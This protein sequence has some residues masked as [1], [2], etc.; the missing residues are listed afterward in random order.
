MPIMNESDSSDDERPRKRKREHRH[1]TTQVAATRTVTGSK[2]RGRY[3]IASLHD[4]ASLPQP[5]FLLHARQQRYGN[6]YG[7]INIADNA[8]A[9]LGD[10]HYSGNIPKLR[11]NPRATFDAYGQTH[12]PCHPAT[13][14]DLLHEIREWAQHSDSKPIFWLNGMAGT[15]KSTVAFTVAQWLEQQEPSEPATLGASF[16]FKRGDGDRASAAHFFST[17]VYQLQQKIPGLKVQID[18]VL[19]D[20]PDICAQA[21]RKQFNKLIENPLQELGSGWQKCIYIVVVDA[22]DECDNENDIRAMLELWPYLFSMVKIGLRLFLTSRPEL[23]IRLG[24]SQMSVDV[25][26]DIILHRVNQQTIEHDIFVYLKD[27]FQQIRHEYNLEPLSGV[28]LPAA[29]P[30]DIVLRDLVSLAVPLFIIAATIC[31]FVQ[32]R[33]CD[34]EQQ[35]KTILTSRRFGHRSHMMGTY[36]PVLQQI[37]SPALDTV[38]RQRVFEEFRLI[39]GA[40]VVL[41]KPLSRNALALLLDKSPGTIAL[42][43]RPLHSV[44]SIPMDADTPIRPLHLSFGEFLTSPDS[45]GQSFH[46]DKTAIHRALFNRCLALLSRPSPIGLCENMCQLDHPGQSVSEVP[47]ENIEERLSSAIAYACHYWFHHARQSQIQFQDD[48]Q[49]HCFLRLHL[50]HWLEAM[51]LTSE[52]D[53]AIGLLSDLQDLVQ[54]S[55]LLTHQTIRVIGLTNEGIS[56]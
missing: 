55:E 24:F 47:K 52:Y 15:G 5:D 22:L 2:E 35:L 33:E 6:I 46:I 14:V 11:Y 41:A 51:A 8:A 25:H 13:R 50:L 23:L 18:K 16:F 53:M 10:V 20:N 44:L 17:I 3:S 49:V 1:P 54:V 37:A 27:N 30:G 28:P 34:P 42:R 21:I 7:N 45:Q 12:T 43:L 26:Q 31:R 9:V 29:W 40:V 38:D 32:D 36:L 56:P 48:D 19:K 39:V 4:N